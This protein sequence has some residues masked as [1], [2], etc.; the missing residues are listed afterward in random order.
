MAKLGIL[1]KLYY[2]SAGSYGSPTF[3]EISLINDLS[4][5]ATWNKGPANSRGSRI[6]KSVKTSLGLTFT[7]T[8]KKK[9]GDATYEELMNAIVSD[10]VLDLLILD[11]AKDLDGVRGWR[12]DC[13]IFEGTED[14]GRDVN[15]YVSLSI[16]PT[17]SDNE[18]Q[19]VLVDGT[20]LTYS[21][22]GVDGDTFA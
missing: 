18:P 19:A 21:T 20:T 17:D 9:P 7:G 12:A 4:V 16:E 8:L 1:S 6:D 15:L 10:N 22:P 3:T 11:G 14:Q 2:R 13:Q 5:N